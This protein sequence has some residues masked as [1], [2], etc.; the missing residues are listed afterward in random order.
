MCDLRD[1]VGHGLVHAVAARVGRGQA[2]QLAELVQHDG[3]HVLPVRLVRVVL[4]LLVHLRKALTSL[5]F[6]KRAVAVHQPLAIVP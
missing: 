6:F 2:P 1:V 3:L 5:S 4:Q